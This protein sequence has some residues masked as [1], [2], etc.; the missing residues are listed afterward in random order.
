[1]SPNRKYLIALGLVAAAAVALILIFA[2]FRGEEGEP[3]PEAVSEEAAPEEGAVPAVTPAGV[4]PSFDI[5]RVGP[6]GDAVIAGRAAPGAEVTVRDGD[7]VLG[8]VQA[9]ERG[10][11]VLLPSEPFASG[12]H[13]LSVTA[14]LP[15]QKEVA[16]EH[17][18]VLAVPERKAGAVPGEEEEALAVLVPREGSGISRV[19]QF[20]EGEAAGPVEG[21]TL[22][23]LNYT[24]DG[25]VAMTGRARPGAM[26]NVYLD[27]EFI[28]SAMADEEGRWEL[29]PES[30]VPPGL[31]TLRVDEI[32]EE[33]EVT[34][35]IETPI[36]HAEPEEIEE[37]M[38]TG[39]AVVQ[40]GNSLWRIARRTYGG[41]RHY[42]LIFEANKD[43]I[44]DPDL[45]YPGQIFSLPEM[46]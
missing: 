19:L 36:L 44:R 32:G 21:V 22:D 26:V 34:A 14:K 41:G 7:K 31:Y 40:P 18:V 43:Q 4:A 17:V 23:T 29:T 42:T 25:G 5:V 12:V 6:T 30:K 8:T 33:G 10:E 11:W 20:P 1:L 46:Q 13:E 39:L 37:A 24:E 27:N 3:S 45:I 15:D 38:R 28:G 9:D 2:V 16:S 35:R